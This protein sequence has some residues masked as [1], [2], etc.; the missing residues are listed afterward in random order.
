MTSLISQNRRPRAILFDNDGVLVASE[1]LHWR[2]W[3][4][5]LNEL[6]LPYHEAELQALVG[7]TSP[8]ILATLLTTHRPGWKHEDY[9]LDALALRKNDHYIKKVGTELRAYPGVLDGLNWLRAQ[10]IKV[11]VVSNAKRRELE[12]AIA[13][14]G[15]ADLFDVIISRDDVPAFKPD[16]TPYLMGAASLGFDVSECLAVEDSPPGIESA[17]MAKIPAA[18]VLTNFARKAMELPVP[19]RPDLKP[20]WVDQSVTDL[21][22]WLKSLA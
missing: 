17:L 12:A 4:L 7:K 19:G 21:F 14:I 15:P 3:G 10:G 11:G 8:E 9:D 16:P 1:P 18:A 13:C 2:A 22:K 6:G 5:L 20:I